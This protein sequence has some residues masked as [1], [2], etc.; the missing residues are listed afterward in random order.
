MGEKR[1]STRTLPSGEKVQ[2]HPPDEAHPEGKMTLIRESS[3]LRDL[4]DASV[5]EDQA[6]LRELEDQ[7]LEVIA[8]KRAD[9]SAK[10]LPPE[11]SPI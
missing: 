7:R 6:R 8:A 11:K 1:V 10:G 3:S 5:G 4:L 2:H 9:Q